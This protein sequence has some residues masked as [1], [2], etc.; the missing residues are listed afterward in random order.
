MLE[1]IGIALAVIIGIVMGMI[2]SGGSVLTIPILVYLIGIS[3][4][5]ATAYSLFIVGTTSLVG[6]VKYFKSGLI[7]IKTV[8]VFAIPSLIAVYFTR[9][10]LIV[11]IPEVLAEVNNFIITKDI[12][13]MLLF[14]ILMIGSSLSM[15]FAKYNSNGEQHS[16]VGFNYILVMFEGIVVG[17]LTGLVGVGGGFLI[18]PTLV[19][20]IRLPMRL[21][22]GT[23]LSIIALKSL[24]GMIGDFQNNVP[25]DWELL[26]GFTGL[27]ILGMLLGIYLSKFVK[28][29][30]LKPAFGWFVLGMGIFIIIKEYINGIS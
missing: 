5:L 9:K 24:L 28:E 25:F 15:I 1:V 14:A 30:K 17:V 19:L 21:A 10:Y 2:G 26:L 8:L 4:T 29:E 16:E 12:F 13:I 22:V 27:S 3:P 20:L 18:I 11:L 7:S 6:S 23:S